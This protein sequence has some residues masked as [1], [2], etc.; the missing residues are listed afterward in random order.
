M[1]T[2]ELFDF[3]RNDTK[4]VNEHPEL[5]KQSNIDFQGLTHKEILRKFECVPANEARQR[6]LEMTKMCGI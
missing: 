3:V 4:L 2:K 5:E 1:S 6:L